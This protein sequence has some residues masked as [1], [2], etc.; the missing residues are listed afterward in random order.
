MSFLALN[1]MASVA[2]IIS[3]TA[4]LHLS[5]SFLKLRKIFSIPE[6]FFASEIAFS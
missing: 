6:I 5:S 3:G 4:P 1:R 2:S